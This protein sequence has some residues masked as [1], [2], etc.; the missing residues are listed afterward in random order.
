[1][2]IDSHIHFNTPTSNS[3]G[4]KISFIEMQLSMIFYFIDKPWSL[5]FFIISQLF[6]N[7][8]LNKFLVFAEILRRVLQPSW[9][10]IYG[11]ALLV[12]RQGQTSL[13]AELCVSLGVCLEIDNW[14]APHSTRHTAPIMMYHCHCFT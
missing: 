12:H 4:S 14:K 1:M 13:C 3:K 11:P 6:C 9:L 7:W 10:A 8:R 2:D 5:I